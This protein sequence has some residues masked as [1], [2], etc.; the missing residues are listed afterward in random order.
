MLIQIPLNIPDVVVKN[1]TL[2]QKSFVLTDAI[3]LNAPQMSA[4][5]RIKIGFVVYVS[6]VC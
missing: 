6:F 5:V 2:L 3:Q 1:R 4:Q